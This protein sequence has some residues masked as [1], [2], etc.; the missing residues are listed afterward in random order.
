LLAVLVIVG[1]L[2]AEWFRENAEYGDS[3]LSTTIA[4]LIHKNT[5]PTTSTFSGSRLSLLALDRDALTSMFASQLG[6]QQGVLSDLSAAPGRNNSLALGFNLHIDA[7][8]IQRVIPV[9]IDG[10][11]SLD[12]QQNIRIAVQQI[13]RDGVVADANATASMQNALNQML[14][15]TVMPMLRS[16]FKGA[17]I[18]S[19]YTSTDIACAQNTEMFVL[20]IEASD[21]TNKA[22]QS[23]PVSFCFKGPIDL[24]KLSPQS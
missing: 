9:E 12:S 23:K 16:A 3:P 2:T 15:T 14:D 11:I 22:A 6:L 18:T 7:S 4:N 19:V 13:K 24:K 21:K 20:Q 17:K 5:G 8:G 10:T 1:G